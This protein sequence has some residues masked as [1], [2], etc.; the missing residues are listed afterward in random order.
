MNILNIIEGH[1][2]EFANINNEI[3]KNRLKI[4]YKCPLYSRIFGGIC[5][6]R[7]WMDADTGDVSVEERSGYIR[8]CGCR[9]LAKTRVANET[10]PADKW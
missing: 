10:C 5:N 1:V 9:L 8:G 2:N 6:N 4:C 3:S 7:L